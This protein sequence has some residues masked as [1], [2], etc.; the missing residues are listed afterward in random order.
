MAFSGTTQECFRHYLRNDKGRDLKCR[1]TLMKFVK[2]SSPTV[3]RWLIDDTKPAGE[4][5]VRLRYFLE[6]QGYRVSELEKLAK[7]VRNFGRLLGLDIASLKDLT[8]ALKMP[9]GTSDSQTLAILRGVQGVSPG[10]SKLMEA[11]TEEFKGLLQEKTAKASI[12]AAEEAGQKLASKVHPALNG[13][14][15]HVNSKEKK[16]LIETFGLMVKSMVPLANLL[17]SDSYTDADREMA[18]EFAGGDGVFNLSN[19]LS[20]LCSE[21]ARREILSKKQSAT[22]G[23]Q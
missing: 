19:C 6:Q 8:L 16:H 4:V 10:R 14:R 20:M 23:R 2:V 17:A 11:F 21:T 3:R 12:A 18:R 9:E 13:S 15:S 22:R 1:E 5:L 7:P